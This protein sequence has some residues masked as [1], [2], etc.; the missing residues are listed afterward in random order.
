MV[1]KVSEY[2]LD[3][4]SA[5]LKPFRLHWYPRLCSTSDQAGRLRRAGR[6]FAPAVVLCGRQTAGRGRGSNS[7][8]SGTDG[9]VLTATFALAVHERLAPQELP[10]IAGLAVRAAAVEL[11]GKPQIQLKWPNDVL[12]EGKKLAGLLCER[13]S[14]VDLLG[15]GLNVNVRASAAPAALRKSLISLQQI[16]GR[17]LDMTDVLLAVAGHLRA[18]VRRRVQQ[19]FSVFVRE[20]SQHDALAGK[21]V[22]VSEGLDQPTVAGRCEG[23]DPAGRLLIRRP[24]GVLLRIVAGNI[25]MMETDRAKERSCPTPPH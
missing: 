13:V 17:R 5:G 21:R 14:N 9:G 8:W 4:L 12:L 11:T 15:V 7:W 25:M 20:Y 24:G 10:L 3:R 1:G 18:A 16:V 2:S 6:L 23:I 22:A 19:P